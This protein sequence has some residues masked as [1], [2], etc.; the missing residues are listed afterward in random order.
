MS[1]VI[2]I[3]W[4]GGKDG[5]AEPSEHEGRY[6][7]AYDP[8]AHYGQGEVWTV[9]DPKDATQFE[10]SM[11]AVAFFRRVSAI[12]PVRDDGITNRP[13]TAFTVVIFDWEEQESERARDGVP[14]YR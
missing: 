13:L 5:P 10:T 9:A 3:E 2:Q 14:R 1:Y 12:R 11:H 7:S 6:V 4:L 8:D